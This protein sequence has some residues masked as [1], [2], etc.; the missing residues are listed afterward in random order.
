[1]KQ[2][3]LT[4]ELPAKKFFT[5]RFRLSTFLY[6][7]I[8]VTALAGNYQPL[9]FLITTEVASGLLKT[10]IN[11]LNEYLKRASGLQSK[12]PSVIQTN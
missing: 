5:G 3:Q 9:T 8:K 1:M 12:Q 6:F 11:I 2:R 7:I 10:L 4:F